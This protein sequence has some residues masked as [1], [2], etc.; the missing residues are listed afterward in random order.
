MIATILLINLL[1]FS[2]FIYFF[3]DVRNDEKN[4]TVKS[5]AG[6]INTYINLSTTPNRVKNQHPFES[7]KD[8]HFLDRL[9]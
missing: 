6:I 8:I 2:D 5:L 7:R 4:F 1:T 9:L 3:F